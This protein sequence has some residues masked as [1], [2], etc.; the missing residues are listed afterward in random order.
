MRPNQHPNRPLH[1]ATTPMKP[2]TVFAMPPDTKTD[3]RSSRCLTMFQP[4]CDMSHRCAKRVVQMHNQ[5]TRSDKVGQ[6]VKDGQLLLRV[7]IS[8][9]SE[10]YL[11]WGVGRSLSV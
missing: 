10:T 6:L 8:V 5:R 11:N 4:L 1:Y 9:L 7:N 2:S 3:T